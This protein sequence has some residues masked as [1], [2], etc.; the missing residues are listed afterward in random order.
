MIP[1][2][3]EYFC[4]ASLPEAISLLSAYQDDAK[5]LAGGQ[6]LISLLK[7][8]LANPKYVVDLGAI[9]HLNYI[10]EEA[11]GRNGRIAIGAMTT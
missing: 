4:P 7:L 11:D 5:I 9:N 2:R 10:R 6:S 8:R 3:F 1:N